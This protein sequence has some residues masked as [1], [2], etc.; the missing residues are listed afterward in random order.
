MNPPSNINGNSENILAKILLYRAFANARIH[1][2]LHGVSVLSW[3]PYSD[4]SHSPTTFPYKCTN[5]AGTLINK[6]R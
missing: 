3:M 5:L 4:S 1:F 2:F 6:I